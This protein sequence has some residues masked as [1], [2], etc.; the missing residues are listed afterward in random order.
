MTNLQVL[1]VLRPQVLVLGPQS[2]WKFSRTSHS[3][4]CPFCMIMWRPY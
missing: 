2:P 3:A 4:N 1:L